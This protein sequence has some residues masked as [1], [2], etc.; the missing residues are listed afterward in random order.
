MTGRDRSVCG[1]AARGDSLQ[2][3]RFAAESCDAADMCGRYTH[4]LT[5]WQIVALY[6]LTLPE[7]PPPGL[8]E[9]FNVA[10]TDTMPIVRPA[11]NGRELVMAGWGLIPYWLRPEELAKRPY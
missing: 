9:S 1:P 8:K 10:P 3:L 7:E 5:W 2:Q 4:K 6:R 11:G